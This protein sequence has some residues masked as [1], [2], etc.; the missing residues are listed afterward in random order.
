MSGIQLSRK[1]LQSSTWMTYLEFLIPSSSDQNAIPT[2][3]VRHVRVTDTFD[4]C[5][6]PR[7]LRRLTSRHIV[8]PRSIVASRR[9]ELLAVLTSQR[10][11]G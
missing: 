3:P 4:R 11:D 10:D 1:A 5:I 9:K 7:D 8:H 2:L 6:V